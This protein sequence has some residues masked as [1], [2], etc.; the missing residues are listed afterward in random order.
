MALKIIFEF[1]LVSKI[2]SNVL[3]TNIESKLTSLTFKH[4]EKLTYEQN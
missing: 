2:T 4:I 3:E 1:H